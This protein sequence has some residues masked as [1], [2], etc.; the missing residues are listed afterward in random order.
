M[1]ALLGVFCIQRLLIRWL[2]RDTSKTLTL[3]PSI[4]GN[5]TVNTLVLQAQDDPSSDA[6]QF[7]KSHKYKGTFS[8]PLQTYFDLARN[9]H[10]SQFL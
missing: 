5:D 7:P 10:P 8:K 4:E 1:L 6:A 3:K 9:E 2:Y